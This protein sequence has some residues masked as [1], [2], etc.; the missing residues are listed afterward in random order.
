MAT[1]KYIDSSMK[2][3]IA[4]IT[5]QSNVTESQEKQ[6]APLADYQNLSFKV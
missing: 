2:N 4:E 3:N 5:K 6:L 1:G